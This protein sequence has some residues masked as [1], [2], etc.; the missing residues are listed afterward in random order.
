MT[1]VCGDGSQ[2]YPEC[3]PYEAI[4][5]AAAAPEVPGRLLEQL[6]EG[7]RLVI[8]VGGFE[9]QELRVISKAGGK[10]S[11]RVSTHCRFVPLRG[12]H[13]FR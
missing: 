7:G 12:H 6:A 13:G 4:S 10:T 2:G 5:V 1:V 9:D 3:A 8:P 11:T